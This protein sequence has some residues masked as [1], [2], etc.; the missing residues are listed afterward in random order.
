MAWLRQGCGECDWTGE[1]QFF[2]Y[3]E[4]L[5]ESGISFAPEHLNNTKHAFVDCC[6]YCRFKEY[7]EADDHIF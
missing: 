2:P 5:V 1:I 6:P 7:Y 3:V 4:T